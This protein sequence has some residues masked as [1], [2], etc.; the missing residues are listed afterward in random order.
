MRTTAT[1]LLALI[2]SVWSVA[3][4]L[5]DSHASPYRAIAERLETGA[6]SA[7]DPRYIAH[8]EQALTDDEIFSLCSREVVRSAASIRL[9]ILDASHRN[10]DSNAQETALANARDTL[11]RSLRCFPRDGN[12]WLRLA[13]VEFARAGPTNSVQGMLQASLATAPSEAWV[14]VPRITFA[15]KLLGS[16]LPGAEAVLRVDVKN[17]VSYGRVSDVADLYVSADEP[18]RRVLEG[19]FDGLDDGRLV[20]IERAIA[21]KAS[22]T[23]DK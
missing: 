16:E 12:L 9:A 5:I 15:L 17:F 10:G 13:M 22:E 19:G 1:I 23:R 14:V 8:I 6:D 7:R 3:T 21:W 2:L 11:R 18:A 20:A 4:I